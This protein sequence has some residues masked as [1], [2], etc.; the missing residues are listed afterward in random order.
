MNRAFSFKVI[1]RQEMKVRDDTFLPREPKEQ[2]G[3]FLSNWSPTRMY[4][5]I[6]LYIFPL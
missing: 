3:H 4:P 5:P 6:Y 2:E 1:L